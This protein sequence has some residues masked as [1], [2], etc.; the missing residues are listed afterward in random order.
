MTSPTGS[1]VYRSGSGDSIYPSDPNIKELEMNPVFHRALFSQDEP[2]SLT[3]RGRRQTKKPEQVIDLTRK[4]QDAA[5]GITKEYSLPYEWP[6]A[7]FAVTDMVN[8]YGSMARNMKNISQ[9]PTSVTISTDVSEKTVVFSDVFSKL[10][11]PGELG[12]MHA[13]GAV[14]A[15]MI[16]D[17]GVYRVV[18][19]A[20]SKE[21]LSVIESI[22]EEKMEMH[23][24]YQGKTLRFSREGVVFINTPSTQ[25]EDVMLPKKT[26]DEHQLNV[27][28]FLSEPKYYENIKKR[29]MLYYGPPGTGKTSIVKAS[30]N[31]LRK[32]G[33]TCLWVSDDTFRKVS[34]ESVFSF[35]NS[36]LAP[37]LVVFEDIDLIAQDRRTATSAIIGP[38]LSALNGIADQ[39]KP[40]AIVATTNRPE[41]LDEAVT[42]PCRFDR[43]IKI[44]HPTSEDLAKM[45]EQKAGFKPDIGAFDQPAEDN[46][47]LTGAHIEEI[48]NT[49]E[50]LSKKAGLS[51]RECV[52]EAVKVIKDNFYLI[53]PGKMGF[54]GDSNEDDDGSGCNGGKPEAAENISIPHSDG[55]PDNPGFFR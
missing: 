38:L 11:I 1:V 51:M 15:V 40:I 8:S 54:G 32:K 44:G 23:N 46:K 29:S 55:H 7:Q 9:A 16:H 22:F 3:A 25:M 37:A 4:Q 48:C 13:S 36:Y 34:V 45:F 18:L 10:E 49:A 24:F 41:I 27:I 30:F 21:D 20:E 53:Q 19:C 31:T 2:K 26:I 52:A 42:R 12:E 35:I 50:L 5:F 39:E 33:V 14:Q 17:C 6:L 28:D 47:K 43:K